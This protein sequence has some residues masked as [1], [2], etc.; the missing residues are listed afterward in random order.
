MPPNQIQPNPNQNSSDQITP[1]E[2]TAVAVEPNQPLPTQPVTTPPKSNVKLVLLI[3]FALF[4]LV[5]IGLTIFFV[6]GSKSN[7]NIALKTVP[8]ETPCYTAG[9]P[10]YYIQNI[11]QAN[12]DQCIGT[13]EL[14]GERTE[15]GKLKITGVGS[16]LGQIQIEPIRTTKSAEYSTSSNLDETVNSLSKSYF[17]QLGETISLKEPIK[18]AG[19]PANLSRFKSA[20]TSTKFKVLITVFAPKEYNIGADVPAKLFLISVTT[21]EDNGQQVLD[22]LISSWRWK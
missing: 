1:Q 16:V 14:W 5:A 19:S 18:L 11:A 21:P 22:A 12:K 20:Q 9:V 13:V 8:Y 10:N 3:V 15:S 6:F 2:Q 7:K 4:A 17:P